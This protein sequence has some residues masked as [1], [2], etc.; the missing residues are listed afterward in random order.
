M[1]EDGIEITLDEEEDEEEEEDEVAN[2]RIFPPWYQ[3]F[4]NMITMFLRNGLLVDVHLQGR[5]GELVPGHQL[6]LAHVSPVLAGILRLDYFQF[7][8][9]FK[10][11]IYSYVQFI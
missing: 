7:K 11:N 10:T 9:F 8:V 1:N 6:I 4:S 2:S 3:R 5:E